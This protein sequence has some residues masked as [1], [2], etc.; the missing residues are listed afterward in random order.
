MARLRHILQVIRQTEHCSGGV[1][2][3]STRSCCGRCTFAQAGVE[4]AQEVDLTLA[5]VRLD[6]DPIAEF[7][8]ILLYLAERRPRRQSGPIRIAGLSKL[9]PGRGHRLGKRG[10]LLV[11]GVGVDRKITEQR[12]AGAICGIRESAEYVG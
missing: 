3:E 6:D 9:Y 8:V 12:S 2:L 10:V 1:L 5:Q 7:Q 11:V 4:A